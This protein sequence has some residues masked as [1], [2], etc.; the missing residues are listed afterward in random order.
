[1]AVI[2]FLGRRLLD[3]DPACYNEGL[4]GSDK[5]CCVGCVC[6]NI[7]C[8]SSFGISIEDLV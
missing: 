3:F 5:G 7:G 8:L 1:M 6:A 4:A 2:R